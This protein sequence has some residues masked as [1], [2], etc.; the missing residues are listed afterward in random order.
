MAALK[1]WHR[2]GVAL[3]HPV[4]WEVE[5][6]TDEETTGWSVTFQSPETAFF[7]L[8]LQ[9]EAA[10]AVSMLDQALDALKSVY[11]NLDSE[12]TVEAMSGIPALGCDIEFITV[13]STVSCWLRAVETVSGPLLAML[14][15]SEL[16]FMKNEPILQAMLESIVIDDDE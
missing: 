6:A 2:S 15:V 11:P 1:S 7:M 16:D 5:V 8:S 9:P 12:S 4:A 3:S 14:Q 10:S 13:D